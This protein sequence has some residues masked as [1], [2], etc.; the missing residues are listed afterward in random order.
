MTFCVDMQWDGPDLTSRHAEHYEMRSIEIAA[1]LICACM[2]HRMNGYD[3]ELPT[4]FLQA[5]L[6]AGKK[7]IVVLTKVN[8]TKLTS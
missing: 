3:D 5:M 7:V 4:N 6:E 1:V 8:L 2:L